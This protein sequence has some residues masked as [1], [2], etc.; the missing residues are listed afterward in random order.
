MVSAR[1]RF[2]QGQV[3]L[4]QQNAIKNAARE[5]LGENVSLQR[6]VQ[7][8]SWGRATNLGRSRH[9]ERDTGHTARSGGQL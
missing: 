2:A 6:P 7:R 3:A 5:T 9:V 4:G 8:A 1:E